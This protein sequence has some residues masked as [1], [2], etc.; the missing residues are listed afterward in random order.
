[1]LAA[2]VIA[3]LFPFFVILNIGLDLRPPKK[4]SQFEWVFIG[5]GLV[6]WLAG[7][8]VRGGIPR[9][10]YLAEFLYR[11]LPLWAYPIAFVIGAIAGRGYRRRNKGRKMP[12]L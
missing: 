11:T 7:F 3:E 10:W 5:L 8:F 2:C 1:M 4:V 12:T 9:G 6:L